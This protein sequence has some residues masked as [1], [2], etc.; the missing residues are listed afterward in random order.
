M[1]HPGMTTR[2]TRI[3]FAVAA[4]IALLLPRWVPCGAPGATCPRPGVLGTTCTAY[5]VE[6]VA[7]YLIELATGRDVAVAYAHGDE[8]H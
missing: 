6:P 5:A 8:C 1:R 3:T 4:V 2:G 7:V